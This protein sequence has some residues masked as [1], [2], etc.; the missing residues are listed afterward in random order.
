M[1]QVNKLLKQMTENMEALAKS[2]NVIGEPITIG[3]RTLI[4]F[5]KVTIG[6]GGGGFQA[7][8]EGSGGKED[9]GTGKGKGMAEAGGSG[10]GAR[11][12]PVAVLCLDK[13]NITMFQMAASGQNKRGLLDKLLEKAPEVAEKLKDVDTEG[14]KSKVKEVMDKAGKA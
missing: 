14:L 1:E 13:D 4:P 7:E 3:D 11:I 8:G 10:G 5:T 2:S 6:L 9:L 12:E